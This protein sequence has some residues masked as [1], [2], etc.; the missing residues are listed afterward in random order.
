MNHTKAL[1]L[2][3]VVDSTRMTEVLGDDAAAAVWTAHDRIARDLLPLW[4]GR[5]IDK[6]DGMLLMFDDAADAA[7]YALAYQHALAG[8]NPPLSARAG[9][10]VGQVVL[11][12]NLRA[13]VER[14]AK[15]LE[16]EGVTKLATARVMSIAMGGQVLLT[17]QARQALDGTSARLQSHGHWRVKGLTDPIELFE[18]GKD[19]CA[20]APPPDAPK[21]YRVVWRDELWLSAARGQTQLACRARPLR[22]PRA[23]AARPG[24]AAAR[25]CAARIGAGHGRDRKDTAGDAFRLV[26]AG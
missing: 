18:L 21:A 2:T 11:R 24:A 7:G 9:L 8:L 26:L 20:F 16:V 5:E 13:D 3:D 22:R 6:T 17:S 19:G 4:R 1:L 14:G 10:H 25:P 15:P 23:G 12:E